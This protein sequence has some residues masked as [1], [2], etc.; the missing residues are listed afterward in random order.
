[1]PF[2]NKS[3]LFFAFLWLAIILSACS[4]PEA[5]PTAT[6]AP[7]LIPTPSGPQELTICTAEEPQSLYMYGDSSSAAQ[8]IRQ[9]IYDGPF[10]LIAGQSVG[11][12]F[13]QTP[14]FENGG[15]RIEAIP[16]QKGD[17]IVDANGGL[18]TLFE[19]LSVRPS[20]CRSGDCAVAYS[21]DNLL[22]PVGFL[23]RLAFATPF[24]GIKVKGSDSNGTYLRSLDTGK[25]VAPAL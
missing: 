17:L 9:A 12:I 5:E 3:H 2:S 24:F 6:P 14:S 11:T 15:L 20:G 1:M 23:K 19:G 21:G 16:V 8:S 22:I 7:T 4:S 13:T 10:D 18:T 25:E